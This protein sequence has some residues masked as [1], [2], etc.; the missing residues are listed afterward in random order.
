[1]DNPQILCQSR[2]ADIFSTINF[3]S[4]ALWTFSFL[5]IFDLDIFLSNIPWMTSSL[6]DN[7]NFADLRPLGRPKITPSAFF[8]GKSFFCSCG[9][10]IPFNLG[11]QP[12]RKS[13]DL[14]VYIV[15]QF[16]MLFCR[17]HHNI[18]FH[19]KVQYTHYLHEISSQSRKLCYHKNIIFPHSF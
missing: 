17:Y 19:T 18:F 2:L 1:M 5:A 16:V 11:G 9:N 3:L 10:K 13:Q 14:G 12:K 15:A 7:F 4:V 6:P 8:S